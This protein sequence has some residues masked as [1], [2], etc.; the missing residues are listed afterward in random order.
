[1]D[2]LEI[3]LV[4]T[5]RVPKTELTLNGV[6]RGLAELKNIIMSTLT[7]ATLD[8]LETMFIA[9][10][11]AREPGRYVRHGR[12]GRARKFIT[13]FGPVCYRLAQMK[14]RTTGR[15]FSPLIEGLK[16]VPYR[17]YQ[18]ESLE[19]AIGQAIH[20]SYRLASRETLRLCGF[21]PSKTTLHRRLQELAQSE[22]HWPSFRARPFKFLM[23]D[24]TV[25]KLQGN[26][27][28]NAG[29]AEMRWAMASEGE[30]QPF[31]PVGFWVGKDWATIG[32]DLRERLNYEDLEV[33]FC[34]GEAGIEE[35]LLAEGMRVQRCVWHG[36]RDFSILLYHDGWK[37]SEQQPLVER[38]EAIPLFY[39]TREV[40]EKVLP[41]EKEVIVGLVEEIK[42]GF[43][44][45]FEALDPEKYPKARTYL[46]NF[47]HQALLVFE[48]WLE[49]KGWI[50]LTTNVI[51]S[52]LSRVVN[53]IK[54]VGKRWSE[55]GLINWLMIAL[56]KIFKPET[57][58]MLWAQYL[59]IH[60]QIELKSVEASYAWI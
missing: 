37:K 44:K 26:R 5:L 6:L 60:R 22:A 14:E 46:E 40:L 17:R 53:R 30:R 9:E 45:L 15:V 21:A 18:G 12:Q 57:W 20:L 35:N 55:K 32:Q 1:M 42:A 47:Y 2:E 58:E 51:E 11:Q 52:A 27:G 29:E 56:R 50:P 28:E 8:A 31:E 19:G 39:L 13:S 3:K 41:P 10:C 33:L 24:G 49:G 36:K 7:Q 25:V 16:A 59:K 43:R 23:V 54:R 38:L 48:Y 34:D 4:L